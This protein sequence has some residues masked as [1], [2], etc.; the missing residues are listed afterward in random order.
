LRQVIGTVLYFT[1]FNLGLNY[2]A[3]PRGDPPHGCAPW[4]GPCWPG[5][6]CWL[7]CCCAAG[8]FPRSRTAPA[9]DRGRLRG[10]ARAGGM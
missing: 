5:W 6:A 4:T 7:P 9:H 10:S 2:R 8:S 1:L 3:D